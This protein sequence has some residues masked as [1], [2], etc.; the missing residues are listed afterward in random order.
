MSNHLSILFA[1]ATMLLSGTLSRTLVGP[2]VKRRLLF[3]KKSPY[4]KCTQTSSGFFI[5][6][7]LYLR[8]FLFCWWERK[9]PC[10]DVWIWIDIRFFC[11]TASF[12]FVWISGY[13]EFRSWIK[14][15]DL[16]KKSWFNSKIWFF[17]KNSN[18]YFTLWRI[19]KLKLNTIAKLFNKL[20]ESH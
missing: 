11:L 1:G 2:Q 20:Y 18:K 19:F 13:K 7:D 6:L 14:S 4:G 15:Y 17:Y 10:L 9:L 3:N 5:S 16:F 8:I 12:V